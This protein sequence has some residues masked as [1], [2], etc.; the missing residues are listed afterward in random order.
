MKMSDGGYRPAYNVQFATDH[1]SDVIVGVAVTN[2]GSD[3]QELVPM[4]SQIAGRV[5]APATL[6]VDGGFVSHA[7]IDETTARGVTVIAPVPRRR[8]S[9]EPV[10]VQATDS[11]AVAAWR[12]RMQTDDAKS[13]YRFRGAIAERINADA[14]THRTLNCLLVR[15]LTKVHAWVLW[16]ALAHNLIRTMDVVPHLMT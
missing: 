1:E 2:A 11:P 14:R 12:V 8:G 15:G 7:A 3:Q 6:L 16:V 13:Q 9:T 4:L 10:P 5:G